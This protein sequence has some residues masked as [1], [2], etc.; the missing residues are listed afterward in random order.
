M[1]ETLTRSENFGVVNSGSRAGYFG[2][3]SQQ[4]PRVTRQSNALLYFYQLREAR[5]LFSIETPW[6]F[7]SNMAIMNIH[8]RQGKESKYQSD[9]TVRFKQISIANS[10]TVTLGNLA[11]RAQGNA[12]AAAPAQNGTLGAR[13]PTIAFQQMVTTGFSSAIQ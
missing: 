12:A 6:G 13:V 4:P 7:W 1:S 3:L 9:F 2:S 10:P 5:V 11:G 8:V